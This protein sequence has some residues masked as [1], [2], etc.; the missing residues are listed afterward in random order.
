M[1][2][3]TI[4]LDPRVIGSG[5]EPIMLNGFRSGKFPIIPNTTQLTGIIITRY[6]NDDD[7]DNRVYAL[8]TMGQC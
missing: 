6:D 1:D 5:L 7:N 2:I 8:V 3:E 4:T